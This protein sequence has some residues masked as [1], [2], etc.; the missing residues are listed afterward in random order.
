MY[1]SKGTSRAEGVRTGDCPR[2][3]RQRLGHWTG[4]GVRRGG[5]AAAMILAATAG[6][7]AD[8]SEAIQQQLRA[9]GYVITEVGRTWLGRVRI[10][11]QLGR[12]RREVVLDPVTGE[13][14]RD[15]VED[16]TQKADRSG[17]MLARRNNDQNGTERDT[18]VVGSPSG[19][20]SDGTVVVRGQDGGT[21]TLEVTNS[22]PPQVTV[23]SGG[24]GG[25]ETPIGAALTEAGRTTV[26]ISGAA[27]SERTPANARTG[28]VPG[29]SAGSDGQNGAGIGS[30]GKS[31][32]VEGGSGGRSVDGG[33]NAGAGS[34]NTKTDGGTGH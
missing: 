12:Y 15:L 34:S 14:R 13:V 2:V 4:R 33:G 1:G 20:V 11:A 29:S 7:L 23:L 25:A 31:G 28:A 24:S 27:T 26:T 30:S 17:G 9:Q 5:L 32:G 21:V 6:A 16:T 8:P 10:E 3:F 18:T 19:A 22:S